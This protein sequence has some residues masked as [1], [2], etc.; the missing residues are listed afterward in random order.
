MSYIDTIV[1]AINDP[2]VRILSQIEIT[3]EEY[4]EL[5]AYSKQRVRNIQPKTIMPSDIFLSVALVQIAIR[6]YHDGNYWD[7]FKEE[8]GVQVSTPRLNLIGQIFN[9]TL[10]EYHLFQIEREYWEKN[11]Y[12]ENI[13]AH[14]Y[15]PTQYISGYFDFL[16][17]F[18]DRNLLRQLPADFSEDYNEMSEF[19][20]STLKDT[21]DSFALRNMDN[22]PAKIFRLLKATR[23]LIAQGDPT[24]LSEILHSHLKIIDDYYYDGVI[25]EGGDRFSVEF[26][27]RIRISSDGIERK[28]KGETR[29][30]GVFYRKPYFHIDRKTGQTFLFIPQQ[31]IRNEDFDHEV[32]VEVHSHKTQLKTRLDLYRAFGILVSNPVKIPVSD[33]FEEYSITIISKTERTFSIPAKNHRFFDNEFNELLRLRNGQNYLLVEKGVKVGGENPVYSNKALPEWDEYSFTGINDESVLYIDNVPVSITG[34]FREGADF[35]SVSSEYTLFNSSGQVQTAFRH[36]VLSFKLSREAVNGSFLLVRDKRIPVKANAASIVDLPAEK[37][38]CGITMVLEDFIDGPDGLYRISI[39]EPRKTIREMCTYVLLRS[40]RCHSEKRKYIFAEEAL[41]SVTGEY[42]LKPV[43]CEKT[44]EGSNY[45]LP[46]KE[47][48]ESADFTLRI[49]GNDFT[50]RVPIV[51]FKH[52]FEGKMT[53]RRP[54]YLWYT[55]LKNDLYISMPGATE[56]TAFLDRKGMYETAHGVP[57]GKGSFRFDISRIAQAIRDSSIPYNRISVRYKDDAIHTMTLYKVLN[58]VVVSRADMFLDEDGWVSV[59][60]KYEGKNDL[61]LRFVEEK[62]GYEAGKRVVTNGINRFPELSGECLYTMH[63]LEVEA[64]PFGFSTVE[65]PVGNPRKRVGAINLY[66][67]SNCVIMLT[68][69]SWGGVKLKF[70][71]YYYAVTNLQKINEYSYSGTLTEQK[72]PSTSGVRGKVRKVSDHVIIECIPEEGRLNVLSLQTEYEEDV[73]DPIYYDKIEQR[74]LC[75]DSVAG[76]DYNRYIAMYDDEAVFETM[77]WRME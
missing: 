28:R 4:K 61:A 3:D 50:V 8:I 16:Y 14:A 1:S 64:D 10:K 15:V 39:D 42:D 20:D 52:G 37:D 19:F 24:V 41:I 55:E 51:V 5:I 22:K 27:K 34:I 36:P 57:T 70:N 49:D 23:V 30:S 12:V 67:V 26:S 75:S 46:L 77:V 56:A 6:K 11:V 71:Y 2:S 76:N 33:L 47:D 63:L 38:S 65:K 18:Y 48:V 59:N 25:P 21:S 73:F 17:S 29:Q 43:N 66:D 31:K 44:E 72:K 9:A 62:T 40:L 74:Y 60:V 13:K 68:G 69:A 32:F 58:R 45:I 7:S 53:S 35:S 54:D